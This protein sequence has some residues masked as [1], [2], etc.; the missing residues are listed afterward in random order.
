MHYQPRLW[1]KFLPWVEFAY[2]ASYHS[3][4]RMSPY[5]AVYGVKPNLLPGYF[6]GEASVESVDELMLQRAAIQQPLQIN[7]QL[8]Q[9]KVKKQADKKRQDKDFAVGEWVWVKLHHFKQGSVAK[10]LNFKLA[11][12][13]Y[14]LFRTIERIWRSSL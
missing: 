3:T 10:R 13:Y 6:P 2:N 12:C 8:A 4:I 14:G 9:Q 1:Y 5:E 7:L 11:K